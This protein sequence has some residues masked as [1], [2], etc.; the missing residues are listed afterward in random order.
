M[1]GGLFMAALGLAVVT[2][3]ETRLALA[4]LLWAVLEKTVRLLLLL[5]M[6]WRQAARP[7]LPGVHPTPV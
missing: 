5:L 7:A 6:L 2:R 1:Y 4:A 3:S